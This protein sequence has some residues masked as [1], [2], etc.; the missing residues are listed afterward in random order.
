MSIS[1][2]NTEV[3]QNCKKETC[4]FIDRVTKTDTVFASEGTV[5]PTGALQANPSQQ[6]P[7]TKKECIDCGLC[8]GY[9]NKSNLEIENEANKFNLEYKKVYTKETGLIK[10]ENKFTEME[11]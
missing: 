8:V 1:I 5:C 4:A 11:L 3:C 6:N 2:I 7:F 9:C 10:V